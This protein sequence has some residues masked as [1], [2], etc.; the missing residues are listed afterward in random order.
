MPAYKRYSYYA[1]K[2]PLVGRL[3]L[4]QQKRPAG[5]PLPEGFN[6]KAL[7]RL[8]EQCGPLTNGKL[9]GGI[10][11]QLGGVDDI[12]SVHILAQQERNFGAPGNNAVYL[13]TA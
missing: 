11:Q 5:K 2:R 12:R 8:T 7:Y 13:L 10:G 4:P 6:G 3:R 1:N 9:N